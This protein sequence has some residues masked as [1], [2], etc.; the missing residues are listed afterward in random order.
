[1]IAQ[2][3]HGQAPEQRSAPTPEGAS[4][5]LGDLAP[6]RLLGLGLAISWDWLVSEH[7]AFGGAQPVGSVAS[8]NTF[9]V[10]A[11]VLA[12]FALAAGSARLQ[13]ISRADL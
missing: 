3:E 13:A 10:I 12:L 4:S 9:V 11:Q 8:L 6:L 2:R 7:L 5:R 1:M